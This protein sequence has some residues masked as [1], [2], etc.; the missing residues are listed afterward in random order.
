MVGGVRA[1]LVLPVRY[2]QTH[3]R[4]HKM[5]LVTICRTMWRTEREQHHNTSTNNMLQSGSSPICVLLSPLGEGLWPLSQLSLGS[6]FQLP[7]FHMVPNLNLISADHGRSPVCWHHCPGVHAQAAQTSAYARL[8][9]RHGRD[10]W[11]ADTLLPL[12]GSCS[13]LDLRVVVLRGKAFKIF[14]SCY[15]T[16]TSLMGHTGGTEILLKAYLHWI[17]LLSF[18]FFVGN[19][20]KWWVWCMTRAFWG[21]F[22]PCHT[23]GMA[24]KLFVQ[25]LRCYM[26]RVGY[27]ISNLICA[28]K[29]C[30]GTLN[31][32]YVQLS[33]ISQNK[34]KQLCGCKGLLISTQNDCRCNPMGSFFVSVSENWSKSCT[35]VQG[36]ICVC[37]CV[38]FPVW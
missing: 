37:I 4:R 28:H 31:V 5:I 12:S 27:F 3:A 10:D 7:Q 21:H 36:F 11:H 16:L 9:G 19:I 8:Q 34:R 24:W 23:H 20:T 25:Q 6:Q 38:L 14:T 29:N 18:A 1:S 2:G 22:N 32:S 33:Q 26:T 15:E 35:L 17:S 13:S 30:E